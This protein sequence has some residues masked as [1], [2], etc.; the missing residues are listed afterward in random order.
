MLDIGWTE[1][2]II[3]VVALIVVGPKDLPK[4][5]RT[6][7]EFTGKARAMAREFQRAMESAA[8]EA[9]VKDVARELRD[10]ASGRKLREASGLDEM[11]RDMRDIERD[12]RFDEKGG[13][14]K[15]GT[16]K[17]GTGKA[18]AGSDT[19]GDDTG[20]FDE[21]GADDLIAAE[22]DADMTRRKAGGAARE[23]Q[24]RIRAERVAEARRKSAD[25]RA[26]RETG[27]D[28]ASGKA[29]TGT[30]ATAPAKRATSKTAA[31]RTA[32]KT[33]ASDTASESKRARGAGKPATGKPATASKAATSKS[34]TGKSAT[35]KAA[36][37]KAT[38]SK[39]GTGERKPRTTR[40]A[41]GKA[42]SPAPDDAAGDGPPRS[43]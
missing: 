26:R 21:E 9:G 1:L 17:A 28:D 7:G 6:L 43:G 37:G 38:A 29:S 18:A 23:E 32:S 40:R 12:M 13:K 8:D 30:T 2:L 42:A 35:G 3:G 19:P 14:G 10:T 22:H 25:I 33:A 34:A 39:T 16:G 4:M 20:G 15:A 11:E 31:T 5:F 41:A 24:R 27:G 36:T